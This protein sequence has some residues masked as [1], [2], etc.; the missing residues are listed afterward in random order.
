[1]EVADEVKR[2]IAAGL[3]LP[4]EQLRDETK[5]E[6]LGAESLDM[7]EIVFD[8]EEKFNIDMTV[9]MGRA[10]TSA[11]APGQLELSDYATVGDVCRIVTTLVAAKAS[12]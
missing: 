4:V 5:L 6:D 11:K 3:K 8:L 7:I 10:Q 12:K 9:K 2:V 1:M